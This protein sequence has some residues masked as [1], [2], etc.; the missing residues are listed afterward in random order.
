[1]IYV[2]EHVGE[3]VFE[4]SRLEYA[5]MSKIVGKEHL[6]FTNIKNKD[7]KEFLEK[8][9]IVNEKSVFTLNLKKACILDPASD[10]LLKP[11][12]S[13]QFDYTIFGGILGDFPAQNRTKEILSDKLRCETR[14]LGKEQMP[15]DTA[16]RVTKMILDGLDF[17]KI[18][19]V[20]EV[21][22]ELSEIESVNLPFRHVVI[23]G[24]P[25]LTPG[26]REYLDKKEDFF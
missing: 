7:D 3:K 21:D 6:M 10:N 4:W 24:K 16:V 5:N 17:N 2:I 18:E 11:S 26:L 12:D 20:D 19:F 25:A 1:M 22:I 15:T 14:N 23:N 13:K 9:G 8:L